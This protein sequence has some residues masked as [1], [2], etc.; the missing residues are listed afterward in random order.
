MDIQPSRDCEFG[1]GSSGRGDLA[2]GAY[3]IIDQDSAPSSVSVA[4]EKLRRRH[5]A[6]VQDYPGDATTMPALLRTLRS[7]AKLTLAQVA[8]ALGVSNPSVW[9]WENGKAK[10]APE[11]LEAIAKVY[12]V[13]AHVL[14]LALEIDRD[15]TAAAARA[16]EDLGFR[17]T[18]LDLAR[19]CV[20]MAYDIEPKAVRIAVEL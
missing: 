5:A 7:E 10:P 1:A 8:K 13:P 14:S 4:E 2:N 17:Q 9:A 20:A 19:Q 18:L 16:H 11:R 12:Q 3:G 15:G 6:P